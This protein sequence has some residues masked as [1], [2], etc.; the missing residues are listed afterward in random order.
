VTRSKDDGQRGDTYPPNLLLRM[1]KEVIYR[2][3]ITK[4]LHLLD[5]YKKS[6]LDQKFQVIRCRTQ[7]EEIYQT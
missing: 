3:A 6:L 1:V 7:M 5:C 2:R 4:K